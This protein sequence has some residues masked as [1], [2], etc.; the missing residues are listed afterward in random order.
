[1][2]LDSLHLLRL[3]FPTFYI[4]SFLFIKIH[5][6]YQYDVSTICFT[7]IGDVQKQWMYVR[8]CLFYRNMKCTE[9]VD[10]CEMLFVLQ[11]YEM[12]KNNEGVSVA[13]IESR[14]PRSLHGLHTLRIYHWY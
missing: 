14:S 11:K 10:V 9:T 8:Y 5:S 3:F 4:F 6:K 1:M 2:N 7:E 13:F 12:Y